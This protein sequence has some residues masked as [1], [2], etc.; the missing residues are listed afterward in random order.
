[1]DYKAT[2]DVPAG[3]A[4]SAPETH[5]LEIAPG[6]CIGVWMY[7]PPGCECWAHLR[8]MWR[9]F[10][11]WPTTPGEWYEGEAMVIE[12]TE[13]LVINDYPFELRIE[14]YNEDSN[15]SHKLRFRVTIL[16]FDE[17]DEAIAMANDTSYGLAGT[18]WTSNLGRAHRLAKKLQAG[19]IGL[20]CQLTFD[21]NVPFG[22]YKQSGLGKEFGYEGIDAYMKTKSIWAQ[23]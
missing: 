18:V 3:T 8:V 15:Y 9:E 19:M 1:M 4:A 12:F 20:N 11:L 10:Q 17:D 16:P 6:V 13:H 21:H 23:L 14:A 7:F 22:G 2:I 5:T